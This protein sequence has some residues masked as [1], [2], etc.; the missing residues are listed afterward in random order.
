[1]IKKILNLIYGFSKVEIFLIII[2]ILIGSIFEILSLGIIIP[3]ISF[4]TDS[5]ENS[6][7]IKYLEN[8]LFTKNLIIKKL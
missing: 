7:I 3:L 2:F 5:P 6:F 1:M 4:F 8:F